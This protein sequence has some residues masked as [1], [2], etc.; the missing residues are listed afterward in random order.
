MT[1]N[2]DA[3]DECAAMLLTVKL[4]APEENMLF[5]V[6]S[7]PPSWQVDPRANRKEIINISK[8]II[9]IIATCASCWCCWHWE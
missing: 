4:G 7:W 6:E 9:R 8:K 2:L 1:P 3:I 5:A